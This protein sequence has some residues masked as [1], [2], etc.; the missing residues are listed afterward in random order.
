MYLIRARVRRYIVAALVLATVGVVAW[1]REEPR[2]RVVVTDT[3]TE[4]LDVVS[5]SLGTALIDPTSFKTLDAVAETLQGNP[6]IALV[7]V[8]DHTS[9]VGDD[10]ANL[11]LSNARA[12]AVTA[13]LVRRGVEASRLTSQGYGDTEP[14]EV[15]APDKNER[16]AFLI[17]KRQND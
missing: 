12:A 10:A 14:L 15:G 3:S 9:G 8:Q 5:F 17:L 16:V 2:G 1:H 4:L 13:Y 11:D 6:G 7:E